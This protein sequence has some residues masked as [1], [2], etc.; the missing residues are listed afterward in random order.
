MKIEFY[1]ITLDGKKVEFNIKKIKSVY[2]NHI[3]LKFSYKN[4]L[5]TGKIVLEEYDLTPE[6]LKKLIEILEDEG[7]KN[8][9]NLISSKEYLKL[10][11]SSEAI[12][13]YEEQISKLPKIES[14]M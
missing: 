3:V 2:M 13:E 10:F 9:F 1:A 4:W 7:F 8:K 14:K 12:I 5:D 11:P 6:S